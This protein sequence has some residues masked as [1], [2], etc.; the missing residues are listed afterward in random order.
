MPAMPAFFKSSAFWAIL[1]P[2]LTAVAAWSANEYQRRVDDAQR[3][4]VA[5][6]TALVRSLQGFYAELQDRDLKRKFVDELQL[7]WLYCPDEVIRKGYAFTDTVMVGAQPS[8][9]EMR[10]AAGEFVAAIREDLLS[11]DSVEDTGLKGSDYL[12]LVV[13]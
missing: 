8:S 3:N 10:K 5:Q 11:R 6:Y 4:K 7:C 1:V 2:A 9:E 13:P 12:H